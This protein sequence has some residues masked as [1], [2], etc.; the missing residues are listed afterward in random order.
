LI[1]K[2]KIL[3]G[4]AENYKDYALDALK[5]VVNKTEEILGKK[6]I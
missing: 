6:N 5:L 1:I 2:K 4:K 3:Y